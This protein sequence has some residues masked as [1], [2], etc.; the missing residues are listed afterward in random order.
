MRQ[1]PP[2]GPELVT[3]TK[4]ET[5]IEAESLSARLE[6]A[7]IKAFLPDQM[8]MQTVA[9]NVNTYGF[10]RVQVAAH[11]YEAARILMMQ[12]LQTPTE[13]G[14]ANESS[15]ASQPLTTPLKITAFVLPVTTFPGLMIYLVTRSTFLRQGSDRK[16]AEWWQW[17]ANGM[18]FWFVT[19]I[20]VLVLKPGRR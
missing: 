5:L 6:V 20:V 17:F 10:V 1:L 11:D 7:G 3:L 4:C 19:F 13:A 14:D 8:L 18:V 12:F 15:S 9:W 16:A 2:D